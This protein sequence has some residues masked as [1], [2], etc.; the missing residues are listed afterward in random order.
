MTEKTLLM[1]HPSYNVNTSTAWFSF[2]AHELLDHHEVTI[3]INIIIIVVV[4]VV[5][6]VSVDTVLFTKIQPNRLLL[7]ARRIYVTCQ[8]PNR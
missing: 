4:I 8:F 5:A 6:V 2:L 3:I 7:S 1:E